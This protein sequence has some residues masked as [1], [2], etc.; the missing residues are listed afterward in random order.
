ML[1]V[2]QL[3]TL[4][5]INAKYKL[6]KKNCTNQMD[7]QQQHQMNDTKHKK[8]NRITENEWKK[9]TKRLNIERKIRETC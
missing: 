4:Q 5:V 8:A 6:T 9:K 2:I 3:A 1:S 7:E